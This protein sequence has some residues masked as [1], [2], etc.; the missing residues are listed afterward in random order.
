[1]KKKYMKLIPLIL[2]PYMWL[3]MILLLVYVPWKSNLTI[4]KLMMLITGVVWLVYSLVIA[5]VSSLQQKAYTPGEAAFMNMLVKLLQI[6]A[7]LI[8]LIVGIIGVPMIALWGLGVFVII[9]MIIVDMS[10]IALTG[11][12]SLGTCT[13]LYRNHVLGKGLSLLCK[14]GSFL[15]CIDVAVAIFMYIAARNHKDASP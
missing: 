1:M 9:L 13:N 6:P 2:Y 11:I 7:Y 10:A 12:Q 4:A 5:V 15:F 3:I 14:T 8:N